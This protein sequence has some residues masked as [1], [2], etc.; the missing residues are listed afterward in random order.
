MLL[1]FTLEDLHRC[2]GDHRIDPHVPRSECGIG[3]MGFEGVAIGPG[4]DDHEIV[5]I[6][7]ALA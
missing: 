7:W 3:D 1:W 4:F 2:S 6:E 5:A